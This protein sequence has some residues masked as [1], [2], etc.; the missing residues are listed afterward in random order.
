MKTVALFGAGQIG[1]MVSRLLGTG[2]G[3]CCFADNSEE[4]WGGEL[5]GIPIVSPRDAL[6]F[7]P[8]AVCICV[9]DD[10]RAAQMRS[11]LDALGYDGEI[12]SP[13]A[14]THRSQIVPPPMPTTISL[15]SK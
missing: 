15:P 6:L 7:D 13:A 3:A 14:Y 1:A 11:Q 9:L 5:A 2:Y 8:D 4:K 12:L 10:E